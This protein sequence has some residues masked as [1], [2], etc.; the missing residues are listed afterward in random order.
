MAMGSQSLLQ[1]QQVSTNPIDFNLHKH[2]QDK[3][4]LN[5]SEDKQMKSKNKI[6]A[7]NR[8]QMEN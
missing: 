8:M 1:S 3:L 7:K 2:I 4:K 5:Q 6:E